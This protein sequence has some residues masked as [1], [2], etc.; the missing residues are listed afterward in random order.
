MAVQACHASLEASR[1]FLTADAGHPHL[2]LCAVRSETQLLAAADLLFQRGLRF[3][4]F[5]EPNRS[6]EATALATEP[7]RGAQRQ[8]LDRF[9]CLRRADLAAGCEEDQ[10]P[11]DAPIG[12]HK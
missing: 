6:H 7:I 5:R 8:L 10:G 3:S 9:R 2:V 4:L 11:G 1:H 12:R